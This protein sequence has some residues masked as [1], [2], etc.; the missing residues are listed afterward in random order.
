MHPIF[1]G[2]RRLLGYMLAWLPVVALALAEFVP[3]WNPAGAADRPLPLLFG[4]GMLLYV[5]STGLC[6]TRRFRPRTRAPPKTARRNWRRYGCRSTRI[7]SST[8]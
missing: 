8:A 1:G 2:G 7:S 5:L 4:L 3:A 6:T